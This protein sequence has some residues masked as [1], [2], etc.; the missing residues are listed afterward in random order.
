MNK[1]Y[2]L[3]PARD[4]QEWEECFSAVPLVHLMQSYV[5]GEAKKRSG[6]WH[7]ERYVVEQGTT[8][9]AIF[10]VI[11]KRVAGLRV[12]SR[13]NRGPLFLGQTVTTDVK[14]NVYRVIKE[15]WKLVRG[16]PLLIAPALEATEEHQQLLA[17]IGFKDRKKR[18]YWSFLLD[19]GPDE[20]EMMARFAPTWRNRLRAACKSGLEL[21]VVNSEESVEWMGRM[22]MENMRRKK[23]NGPSSSFIATLYRTNPNAF[24][25]LQ[26]LADRVPVAGMALVSYGHT[27]H[28]Y[29][30]WFDDAAR[31]LNPGNFLY[32][33]SA[34]EMKKAGYRWLDLGGGGHTN[35]HVGQFKRGTRCSEYRLIGEWLCY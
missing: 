5:Y 14:E 25:V 29:V 33:H 17:E 9:V 15:N 35:D 20:K 28:Y 30:G 12:A 24:L 21:N 13:I 7:I 22:H 32:W 4:A 34:L 18:G 6:N 31:K 26:A 2:R 11:E 10:Q 1:G 3:R 27:A 23:F 19:L 16:G 8:P